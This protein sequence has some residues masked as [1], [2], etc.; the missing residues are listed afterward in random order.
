MTTE[1]VC[2]NLASP[3]QSWGDRSKFWRRDS[4]PF[5][6]KSALTGL[7]F[8][9]MGLD[10]AQEAKLRELSQL[11]LIVYEIA[12]KGQEQQPFLTDFHMVGNGYD[13]SDPWQ[14]LLIPKTNQGKKAVGGGAKITYRQY[15]Q[16]AHFVAFFEIPSSWK[17]DVADALVHPKWDIYL[18]RK[19]CAPSEPVF[20]GFVP[21]QDAANQALLDLLKE[22]SSDS[23]QEWEIRRCIHDSDGNNPNA[24]LLQDVPVRFGEVKRYDTRYVEIE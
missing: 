16:D 19:S 22:K 24:V 8:C 13:D 9:A 7:F 2:L 18:G 20:H 12:P 6:T 1:F 17:E 21:N 5:P 4:L 14:T 23:G 15:L 3:L 11:R 10:G